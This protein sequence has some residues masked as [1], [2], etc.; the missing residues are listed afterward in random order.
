M[1]D[2]LDFPSIA[3]QDG[4]ASSKEA[5]QKMNESGKRQSDCEQVLDLVRRWPGVTTE[6][7]SSLSG[8]TKH[9]LGRRLS[10]LFRKSRVRRTGGRSKGMG[11]FRWWPA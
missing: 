3:R 7:L 2:Q 5:A 1:G 9:D 6:E 11:P 8:W 4:P 10:D